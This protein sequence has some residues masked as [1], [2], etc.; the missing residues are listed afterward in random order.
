MI[1]DDLKFFTQSALIVVNRF[2]DESP[3]GVDSAIQNMTIPPI[4][5]SQ[6]PRIALVAMVSAPLPP[7]IDYFMHAA[8]ANKDKGFVFRLKPN[9]KNK[10]I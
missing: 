7:W 6:E 8:A 5:P 3:T 1:E 10:N 4:D 2:P 9:R